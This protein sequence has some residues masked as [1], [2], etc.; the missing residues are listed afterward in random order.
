MVDGAGA[1]A[2]EGSGVATDEGERAGGMADSEVLGADGC[3]AEYV[4]EVVKLEVAGLAG[5]GFLGG[6]GIEDAVA[7]PVGEAVG[8]VGSGGVG[9]GGE[10]G[11]AV[12]IVNVVGW[13]VEE[14]GELLVEVE[15][16]KGVGGALV[17]AGFEKLRSEWE[18]ERGVRLHEV[19]EGEGAP[20]EEEGLVGVELAQEGAEVELGVLEKEGIGATGVEV[21]EHVGEGGLGGFAGGGGEEVGEERGKAGVLPGLGEG[22]LVKGGVGEVVGA[23]DF[24][25]GAGG[26]EGFG[27]GGSA[28]EGKGGV[29]EGVGGDGGDLGPGG[30]VFG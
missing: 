4:G 3:D 7:A 24:G 26:E 1:A 2:R 16:G 10:L 19:E 27:D 23:A 25:G 5:G 13:E 11:H 18:G 20:H 15:F 30:R 8:A 6:F 21:E 12:F 22:V 29:L 9:L 14:G 28:G 17:A